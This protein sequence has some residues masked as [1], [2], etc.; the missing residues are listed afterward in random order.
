MLPS[1]PNE[2]RQHSLN[3]QLNFPLKHKKTPNKTGVK[4]LLP[5]MKINGQ[6]SYNQLKI[7]YRCTNKII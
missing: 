1:L 6:K 3:K 7:S 2:S 5:K 4:K